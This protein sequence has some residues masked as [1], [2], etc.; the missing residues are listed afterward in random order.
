L[1]CRNNASSVYGNYFEGSGIVTAV[2]GNAPSSDIAP[3][4]DMATRSGIPAGASIAPSFGMTPVAG[5]A[6]FAG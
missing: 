2:A 5:I 4:F 6:L 3:G 1:A